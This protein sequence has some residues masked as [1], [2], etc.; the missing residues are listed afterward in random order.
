M[1]CSLCSKTWPAKLCAS[2]CSVLTCSAA[3]V[4]PSIAQT[5]IGTKV[6]QKPLD[7]P[8]KSLLDALL[9]CMTARAQ[10]KIQG[11][12]WKC[13]HRLVVNTSR[14]IWCMTQVALVCL[15]AVCLSSLR[16][17]PEASRSCWEGQPSTCSAEPSLNAWSAA[18]RFWTLRPSRSTPAMMAATHQSTGYCPHLLP[19]WILC[20][21]CFPELA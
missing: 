12:C 14:Q 16:P 3:W 9:P 8:L 20:A 18:I 13:A 2:A 10:S 7:A 19:D 21:T 4:L 5:S 17:L 1:C 11:Q 15:D 6:H